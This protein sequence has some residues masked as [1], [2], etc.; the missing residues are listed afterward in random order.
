M[1]EARTPRRLVAILAADVVGYSRMMARNEARTLSTLRELRE[2][3]LDPG[4]ERFHGRT[5]KTMGDGVIVE[6]ES[7]VDGVE[8]AV[9]IQAALAQRMNSLRLRIGI[10]VGDVVIEGDDILGDGVN[11]AARLERIAEPGGIALSDLVRESIHGRLEITLRDAGQ[12]EL[13]NIDR[14]VRVWRWLP[15]DASV[16]DS[17]AQPESGRPSIA[18]LP[19]SNLSDDP[20]QEFFAD[21][22]VEDIITGLSRYPLLF[23][24]ARNSSLTYKGK[25]VDVVRV[26][27]ELGVRYVVEG[28]IR[29]FGDRLRITAQLIDATSGNH[30]WADRYDSDLE[31]ALLLQDEI[32]DS[33]VAAI[34]PEFLNAEMRRANRR[35]ESNPD[36]WESF[37]R[38]FWHLARFTREDFA[39]VHRLSQV[40]IS[41]DPN[42]ARPYTLI[43]VA[44]IIGA[45]YGW[46]SDRIQAL[47]AARNAATNA[48]ALDPL[49]SLCA[50][51]MGHVNLYDRRH[52]DAGRDFLR[53]IELCPTEAENYALL[54]SATGL[55][56]RYEEALESFQR[57]RRMSPRDPFCATWFGHLSMCAILVHRYEGSGQLGSA[58][59]PVAPGISRWIS[60]ARIGIGASGRDRRGEVCTEPDE[61]TPA[62]GVLRS[63]PSESPDRERA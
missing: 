47:T 50:R 28:S 24:I 2:D 15:E 1:T 62:R 48:V 43:V 23:I 36:A 42:A 11:V 19:F 18:V 27:S 54:G 46:E 33:I 31:K 41:Q 39:E 16:E 56:G 6:F 53:A 57:A 58:V 40:A 17:A 37:M 8:C 9:E 21:G 22:V 10:N 63:S 51:A 35:R 30:V 44:H 49:S 32:A 25:K 20:E 5:V 13:K 38:A 7:A 55:S 14:P 3:V 59:D 52:E 45:L 4:I 29:R 34:E 61:R 12:R 60:L 26:A